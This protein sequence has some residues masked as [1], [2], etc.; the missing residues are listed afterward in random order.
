MSL[1]LLVLFGILTLGS[2]PLLAAGAD[3]VTAKV[4]PHPTW[5]EPLTAARIAALPA[6]KKIAWQNYLAQS[7]KLAAADRAFMAAE[8][9][10][11]KLSA[12]TLAPKATVFGVDL[13]QP[14]AWFATAEGRQVTATIISYQTPAGGWSKRLDL[15]KGPRPRGGDFVSES[16]GAYEGTFDND[17]TITQL[18]A[19]ARA[20]QATNS[21]PARAAFLRGLAYTFAA[22]YPN[23]GWPQVFPLEGGYHDAVTY[24]DN[25]MVNILEFLS[26][27][28]AGKDEFS[29]VPAA[30]RAEAA[31]RVNLGIACILASQVTENKV[32][33][34]WCQQHDPLTLQPCGARNYEPACLSSAESAAIM[35]FL[36]ERPS[37]SQAIASAIDACAAWLQRSALH[38]VTWARTEDKGRRLQ[39]SRE[40]KPLWARYYEL[41]TNRPI[42]GDRD[43]SVHYNVDE[44]SDERRNGYAWYS[45]GPVKQLQ[46]YDNWREARGH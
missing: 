4:V 43:F 22:Q 8:L 28:A 5:F 6:D 23:G 27:V 12:P 45:S 37:P 16:A 3:P 11:A 44:I 42:F 25:A 41:G 38:G 2:V 30:Q 40:G 1:R 20:I 26:D 29:L 15:S 19:L 7:E 9:V 46:A 31:D 17:A 33:T 36:I 32:L 24:N 10:T 21:E 39:P 13:D 35:G 34:A 18:R 14:V